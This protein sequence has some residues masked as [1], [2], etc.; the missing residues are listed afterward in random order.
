M[1]KNFHV[2]P[3]YHYEITACAEKRAMTSR[4]L[5]RTGFEKPPSSP[6]P[7]FGSLTVLAAIDANS[8]AVK[9]GDRLG[10]MHGFQL[11]A[12][13]PSSL[14][15][16]APR[17]QE[18][19]G[20]EIPEITDD[21]G[22]RARLVCGSFWGKRGPV[23]GIASDPIYVDVSVP[24]GKQKTLPVETT[25]HAFAY[26]F[27]GSGKFCNASTP[28][29]MPTE[30]LK[31]LETSPPTEAS[32]RS[33]ILFDSGE[34][35]EVQAGDEGIRFLLVSGK[36]LQEPIA[37][38]GPIV[39]I[40]FAGQLT[41]SL[42]FWL[43][44]WLEKWAANRQIKDAALAVVVGPRNGDVLAMPATPGLLDFAK[45]HGLSFII[46]ESFAGK[47]IA[48]LSPKSMS[49]NVMPPS[50]VQFGLWLHQIMNLIGIGA[51]TS[52]HHKVAER[53]MNIKTKRRIW[54]IQ[55]HANT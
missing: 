49:K 53:L 37:W 5:I 23:E 12:N 30:G 24:P 2:K 6:Y 10:Q 36:P 20:P 54:F 25:R 21:D 51:S 17:Y 48:K 13:L 41:Q 33:L 35:V 55:Y 52:E 15:M 16:T 9:T 8:G 14:K 19:K 31:W 27:A 22:T 26:V 47:R 1:G 40:V 43:K 46:D 28:L 44:D 50:L 34:S 29:A 32:N 4:V 38:Y 39:M 7:G 42:P 18:I 11:W 45:N 3:V